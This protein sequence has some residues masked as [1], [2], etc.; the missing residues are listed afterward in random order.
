VTA[1]GA[2]TN[3]PGRGRVRHGRNLGSFLWTVNV[4]RADVA[5]FMLDQLASSTCLRA[6]PGLVRGSAPGARDTVDNRGLPS[7]EGGG[8]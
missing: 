5:G 6:A 7:R 3:G 2:L 8:P 4:S 1:P